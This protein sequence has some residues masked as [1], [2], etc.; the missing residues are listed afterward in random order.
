[1]LCAVAAGGRGSLTFELAC[2]HGVRCTLVDP[3]PLKL[4]K[5]QHKQLAGRS[6]QVSTLTMQ[7]LQE[8]NTNA[9]AHT[10][11]QC[12]E[13]QEQGGEQEGQ[14]ADQQGVQ[15]GA[16]AAQL[17]S[18]APPLAQQEPQSDS[19]SSSSSMAPLQLQQVQAWFGADLWSMPG[20]QRLFSDCSLVVGL[21][22]DQATEPILDFAVQQRLPFAV[23]PCCVFPRLFPGRRLQQDDGSLVPVSSYE[24]LVSYLVQRGGAQRRVLDFEGA[25]TVVYRGGSMYL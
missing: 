14:S 12:E 1:M 6:L 7:Q 10:L 11:A 8:K 25:N 17:S 23:M 20:W 3:R 16:G 9:A 2:V 19:S 4:N 21:H 13:N 15:G 5:L 18:S 24:E 22:P